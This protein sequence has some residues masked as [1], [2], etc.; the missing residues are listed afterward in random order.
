MKHTRSAH[1]YAIQQ[2]KSAAERTAEK[3]KAKAQAL[4]T[5]KRHAEKI[6]KQLATIDETQDGNPNKEAALL[7]ISSGAA[8]VLKNAGQ[9]LAATLYELSQHEPTPKP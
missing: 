5:I 8:A 6:A 4:A 2:T 7:F 1:A 9:L 3:L